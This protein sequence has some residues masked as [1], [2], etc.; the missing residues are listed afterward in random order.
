MRRVTSLRPAI[1][2]ASSAAIGLTLLGLDPAQGA[3]LPDRAV[4]EV[5][6]APTRQTEGHPEDL[7]RQTLPTG[8]RVTYQLSPDGPE[9]V[10]VEPAPGSTGRY[11]TVRDGS[12]VRVLPEEVTGLVAAGVVD[13]ALF[14]IGGEARGG[15]VA[16]PEMVA[17]GLDE[18][19]RLAVPSDPAA[20]AEQ[21]L[22]L[23]SGGLGDTGMAA[24]GG[25]G[26]SF[27][28]LADGVQRLESTVDD[29]AAHEDG[30]APSSPTCDLNAN[31]NEPGP[32]RVPVTISAVDRNGDPVGGS[33]ILHD[34]EC[35]AWEFAGY[36]EF[37]APAQGKTFYL[38]PSTYNLMGRVNTLDASG[39]FVQEVTFGGDAQ[40][41]L[42]GPADIVVDARDAVPLEFETPRTSSPTL[43]TLGWT[44]GNGEHALASAQV[45]SPQYD[46]IERVSVI[47]TG[48]VGEEK[49]AFYPTARAAAPIVEA[50]LVSGAGREPLHAKLLT[51]GAA[52]RDGQ[53]PVEP[54]SSGCDGCVMVVTET[55][56][57]SPSKTIAK[58]RHAGAVAVAVV[59]ET[60]GRFYAKVMDDYPVIALT[61][62]E[63]AALV[64]RLER[65]EQVRLDLTLT[66][67]TPYLYDLALHEFG[68]IPADATFRFDASNT[69]E[70]TSAFGQGEGELLTFESRYPVS[71]CRCSLQVM[72]DRHLL[73]RERVDYVSTNKTL[74]SQQIQ[75]PESALRGR[76]AYRNYAAADAPTREDWFTGVMA[77]GVPVVSAR[78]PQQPAQT[79]DGEL[80]FQL[81]ARTD[82][83]GHPVFGGSTT[84]QISRDGSVITD[85]TG[86]AQVPHSG[87]A[88]QWEV[89][90]RTDVEADAWQDATSATSR[91]T[92]TSDAE[93]G[94]R[95]RDLPLLDALVRLEPNQLGGG[96]DGQVAVITPWRADGTEPEVAAITV[97]VSADEGETWSELP[98]SSTVGEHRAVLPG[99]PGEH[100]L[101]L[102]LVDQEGSSL[103]RTVLG[104]W[105]G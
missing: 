78:D 69:H 6:A 100:A 9:L 36:I 89:E 65:G 72:L 18:T 80:R 103:A 35:R 104:A 74:W 97:E 30:T 4:D 92:F 56:G 47:P 40:I 98:V 11:R 93:A 59:P 81:A 62:D 12:W 3:G 16:G 33:F 20:A 51:V 8:D 17:V 57:T 94:S 10:W 71:P 7:V 101:R 14:S 58:A 99:S 66:P 55:P 31:P 44:R 28:P 26:D 90:L 23:T 52:E 83:S 76:T 27:A 61:H 2:L 34:P 19:E 60:P 70:V 75:A 38:P 1:A 53:L 102:H 88:A 25:P 15:E 67:Y 24:S 96:Q 79:L 85:F 54:Y 32:G 105:S 77:P 82:A 43:L 37:L 64:D 21:W 46:S 84:G 45:L 5:A 68:H 91:W 42:V 63:G 86:V 22:D 87:A 73:G 95:A 39:R 49:F 29:L 13:P 50:T 41:D 48:D